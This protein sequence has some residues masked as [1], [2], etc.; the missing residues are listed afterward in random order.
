LMALRVRQSA[1]TCASGPSSSKHHQPLTSHPSLLALRPSPL[2]VTSHRHLLPSPLTVTSHCHFSPS[3]LTV[4]S[5]RHSTILY[6]R[7]HVRR[8]ELSRG[9]FDVVSVVNNDSQEKHEVRHR[10]SGGTTPAALSNEELSASVSA[11][12]IGGLLKLCVHNCVMHPD[13]KRMYH[14]PTWFPAV[15]AFDETVQNDEVPNHTC[16][17]YYYAP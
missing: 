13:M 17:N 11:S 6:A 4:T 15:R 5:H 7:V 16:P 12:D 8:Y 2:I 9:E 10:A 1:H 3:P 14:K